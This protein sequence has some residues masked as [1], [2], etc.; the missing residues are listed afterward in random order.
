VASGIGATRE[1]AVY[2]PSSQRAGGYAGSTVPLSTVC[3]LVSTARIETLR[4]PAGRKASGKGRWQTAGTAEIAGRQAID[5]RLP[6]QAASRELARNAVSA[7]LGTCDLCKIPRC[8]TVARL[9]GMSR[10]HCLGTSGTAF[11]KNDPLFSLTNG[12]ERQP[13]SLAY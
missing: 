12:T 6:R 10:E 1:L 3:G 11:P 2:P 4:L 13:V 7:R 5:M 9:L 8:D